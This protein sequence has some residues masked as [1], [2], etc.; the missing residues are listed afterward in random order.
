MNEHDA[1][2]A[3]PETT[4]DPP[5][6]GRVGDALWAAL[7]PLV[8]VDKP[9][10][11]PG[12]PR[13]DDRPIFDGRI[14]IAR[15][16]GQWAARPREFGPKS[17]GHDRRQE[18]V[19]HGNFEAAWARFLAADDGEGGL[20]REW[21][22]AD[23]CLLK[24]PRGNKGGPARRR[25]PGATP[26]TGGKCGTKRHL[27]TDGRGRA[28]GGGPQ[29]G[30]SHRHEAAGRAAR[31]PAL[32]SPAAA[33]EARHLCLDRGDDD[34]QCRE[35]AAARGDTPH[36]PPKRERGAAAARRRAT[37]TATR[38]G[39][40][41]SRSGTAGSTASAACSSAGSKHAA[42]YL[43]FVQL[44]A[45]LIIYRKLRHARS[46]SGEAVSRR[47]GAG[48]HRGGEPDL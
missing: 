10:Q 8:V 36:I 14:W 40:G 23:G 48:D 5:T 17:T 42:N 34:D 45:I 13:S 9:R 11:K 27:L 41:W 26:P 32:R 18:W 7:Q 1:A 47:G 33:G 22:A 37:P 3:A 35:V 29:R 38:P 20:D 30:Q 15:S 25:R 12:R 6:I 19:E 21:Q 46:L 43:A 16:G 28:A 2:A 39:A 24:A 31:R 4:K 44:A